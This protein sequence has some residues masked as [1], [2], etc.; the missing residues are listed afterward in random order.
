[1]RRAAVV[2]FLGVLGVAGCSGGGSPEGASSAPATSAASLTP[3]TSPT[4]APRATFGTVT[5]LRDALVA[6][7]YPCPAWEQT[8]VVS[9][10]AQ[11]GSCSDADVLSVYVG[12]EG[13]DVVVATLKELGGASLLVGDNWILNSPDAPALQAKMGGVVVTG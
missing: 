4:Q 12:T 1:M 7:G 11:S 9:A 8:D 3:T 10:A 13:R 6:A 2:A 5:E